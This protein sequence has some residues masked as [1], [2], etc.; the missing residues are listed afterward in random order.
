LR[1]IHQFHVDWRVDL[2]IQLPLVGYAMRKV[3]ESN[4]RLSSGCCGR[5]FGYFTAAVI[6]LGLATSL[7]PSAAVAAD[8]EVIIDRARLVKLPDRVATIVIGNPLIADAVIQTG[9]L[10]VITGKSFG[11]TNIVALDRSGAVLVEHSIDVRARQ[12]NLVVV[13]KGVERE[14]YSCA[15]VCE[16]RIMLGD[17]KDYF[18]ATLGQ[19][20]ARNTQAQA[21]S[22]KP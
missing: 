21:T 12:D 18:D 13:F 20:G 11:A 17:G 8:I 1:F 3:R 10:L 14:T 2:L 6:G 5:A 15:Q 19:T 7:T 4:M 9:G 16:R 22:G